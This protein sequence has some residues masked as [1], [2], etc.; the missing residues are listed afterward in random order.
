[1][2]NTAVCVLHT[3]VHCGPGQGRST[4]ILDPVHKQSPRAPPQNPQ[5][6]ILASLWTLLCPR[7]P[8]GLACEGFRKT[9]VNHQACRLFEEAG[10]CDTPEKTITFHE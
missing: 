1:M 8:K 9:A 4:K 10:S 6:V 2:E 7:T 5:L 3:S